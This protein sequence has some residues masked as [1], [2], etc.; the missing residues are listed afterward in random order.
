MHRYLLS[1]LARALLTA[2]LAVTF[3]FFILR[4]TGDPA[5]EILGN[6]ASPEALAAFRAAWG[7][8]HS[9]PIQFGYYLK[10][11]LTGDFGQ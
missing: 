9:L 4:L 2:L 8:D 3:T 6:E 5:V 7:L 11:V 10:A 1:R